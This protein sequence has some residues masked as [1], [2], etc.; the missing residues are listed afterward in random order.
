[1]L[2]NHEDWLEEEQWLCAQ[3]ENPFER[4]DTILPALFPEEI[5]SR[6]SA[7][8]LIDDG[9]VWVGNKVGKASTKGGAGD[10]IHV[11]MP[12]PAEILAVG[13]DI[14]LDI[15]Y[16][17]ADIIVVNKRRGMVVHPAAGNP[18]G[19]L[20]NALL[21]HCKDLSAI[22]GVVRP[23]IVHRIDKDTTGLLVVAKND[24]AHLA[25]S[26]QLKD[27]SMH[28]IYMAVVE[29]IIK[30]EEGTVSAKI[31]RSLRD[32]KKMGV[33]PTGRDAIT[34]YTVVDRNFQS[35]TTLVSCKLET[36]RTHQIRVH[37]AY[38]GHPVV[39]DPVYGL[40]NS[41]GMAG[42]ALHAYRLV[43]R[44]PVQGDERIFY[45]PPP[46]DFNRLLKT[47]H[48]SKGEEGL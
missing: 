48:L 23:G 35:R 27:H 10:E 16:E 38:L 3:A 45:A 41:R 12:P 39:G 44:H 25:L 13:E 28:R 40:K 20:V 47:C 37:M 34:H 46:E 36:G 30:D 15:V 14:P 19:T 31:G 21:Y 22:G 43:L 5:N 11:L 17:D 24:K 7:R 18:K 9:R 29:G 2:R 26:A 8:K 42:Q 32:R 4:L 33:V 1:M 6:S